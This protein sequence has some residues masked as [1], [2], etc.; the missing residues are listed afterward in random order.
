VLDDLTFIDEDSR[1]SNSEDR[2]VGTKYLIERFC[3]V[4]KK[5][6]PTSY[7]DS[8]YCRD[9]LKGLVDDCAWYH[10]YDLIELVA[11]DLL[12]ATKSKDK[13]KSPYTG[14]PSFIKEWIDRFGFGQY[15]TKVNALFEEEHI[16]WRLTESGLV[17]R[18][19]PNEIEQG[20]KATEKAL[21]GRFDPALQHYEKAR[22]Y[23]FERPF[24]P[25]NAIKEI[26]TAL[27]SVALVLSPTRVAT[28]G[29]AAKALKKQQAA[30]DMLLLVI[31]RV[32]AYANAEPGV[33]HGKPVSPRA[34]R[35]EADFTFHTGAALMR[36]LIE[37]INDEVTEPEEEPQKS[38]GLGSQ[39]DN[40]YGGYGSNTDDEIPF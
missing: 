3:R 21:K 25:E 8:W 9:I 13:H 11:K 26:V 38:E 33:R 32:W 2:P 16:G 31:E 39:L 36:Y 20:L 6:R 4:M 23:L 34:T 19:L 22:R 18:L 14:Y 17:S 10:F 27:E 28:L 40:D 7:T 30:P 5:E 35:R 29:D 12:A 15:R 24:D 1:Y 37:H